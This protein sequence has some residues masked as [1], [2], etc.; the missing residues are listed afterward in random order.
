MGSRGSVTYNEYF[1][2]EQGIRLKIK[3]YVIGF[4][5]LERITWEKS[6]ASLLEKVRKLKKKKKKRR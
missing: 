5:K 3:K 1:S 2:L 6:S 4:L